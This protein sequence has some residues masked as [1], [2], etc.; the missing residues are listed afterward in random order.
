MMSAGIRREAAHVRRPDHLEVDVVVVLL[1]PFHVNATRPVRRRAGRLVAAHEVRAQPGGRATSR[2]HRQSSVAGQ[3]RDCKPG[4]DPGRTSPWAGRTPR[5]DTPLPGS[6]RAASRPHTGAP[7][8]LLARGSA[9]SAG[10]AHRQRHH[11]PRLGCSC[12]KPARTSAVEFRQTPAA[13]SPSRKRRP[14]LNTSLRRRSSARRLLRDSSRSFPA[15]AGP[16]LS[17]WL[18]F[19]S[20]PAAHSLARPKSRTRRSFRAHHHVP[21]EVGGHAPAACPRERPRSESHPQHVVETHPARDRV[22]ARHA[23]HDDEV[24]SSAESTS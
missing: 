18:S 7:L 2:D 14:K 1:A 17:V 11:F 15:L 16:R 12:I 23:L 6:A 22:L 10:P 13:P 9:G 4:H 8:R 24:D 21:G 3:A 20:V 19:G 5:P